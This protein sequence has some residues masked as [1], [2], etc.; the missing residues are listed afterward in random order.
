MS[1]KKALYLSISNNKGIQKTTVK[2]L[3]SYYGAIKVPNGNNSLILGPSI[4]GVHS[5]K[6]MCII[7]NKD[8]LTTTTNI[9]TKKQN[10]SDIL[11][12]VAPIESI[13]ICESKR[14]NTKN[15][16]NKQDGI[17]S[18]ICIIGYRRL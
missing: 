6:S 3:L 10:D 17:P 13:C 14:I 4:V 12:L 16:N 15:N 18:H 8:N 1:N 5:Y 2:H 11:F 9:A 7:R